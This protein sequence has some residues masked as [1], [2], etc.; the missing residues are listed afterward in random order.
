M[1]DVFLSFSH[2]NSEAAG[3]IAK[4]VR[5]ETGL[6]VHEF[7]S[8][9]HGVPLGTEWES[10]LFA[11]MRMCEVLLVVHSEQWRKSAW[12][13]AEYALAR[14]MQKLILPVRIDN[15]PLEGGMAMIQARSDEAP[16][17]VVAEVHRAVDEIR[18][19]SDRLP[20][21]QDHRPPYPGGRPFDREDAGVFFGRR[22]EIEDG[23]TACRSWLDGRT[24]GLLLLAGDS[25]C[26]K[27]SV[28]RAGLLPR[29]A[30]WR[31]AAFV[32]I[33][34]DLPAKS[35]LRAVREAVAADLGEP[36]SE[37]P[38]PTADEAAD[39]LRDDL[40][41]LVEGASPVVLAIDELERAAFPDGERLR[42]ALAV[43]AKVATRHP[44]RL[45]VVV[46][47]RAR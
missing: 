21:A 17:E 24:A 43:V 5:D 11:E 9:R 45:L 40:E 25:G 16:T 13:F 47:V 44:G 2:E 33:E 19:R 31:P 39:Q 26:G 20:L 41:R 4:Q 1:A 29:L 35:P 46:T 42:R 10:R 6:S 36:R 12:C 37:R 15:A 23:L 27:T 32:C 18:R 28:M 22:D 3:R 7:S 38:A 34:P 14:S 30:R 8:R